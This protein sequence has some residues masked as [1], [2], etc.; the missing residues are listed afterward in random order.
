MKTA[1][2]KPVPLKHRQWQEEDYKPAGLVEHSHTILKCSACG[3]ELLDV[4]VTEPQFDVTFRYK[5]DCPYC[6]DHSFLTPPIKGGVYIGTRGDTV[7]DGHGGVID[8]EVTLK[9]SRRTPK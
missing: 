5:A 6:G 4:M 9:T 8:D 2:G 7:Y 1:T 3:A